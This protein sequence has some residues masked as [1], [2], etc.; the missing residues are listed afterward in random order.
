MNRKKQLFAAFVL[1][2]SQVLILF[3]VITWTQNQFNINTPFI[4][5]LS[6][7][8]IVLVSVLLI[9]TILTWVVPKFLREKL[10]SLMVLLTLFVFIQQNILV[11]DYG[12][13]DGKEIHFSEAGWISWVEF[14]MW[15]FGLF[16]LIFLNKKVLKHASLILTFSGLASVAVTFS[17][18]FSYDFA[19]N[20][21]SFAISE[22]QKFDY[23]KNKN[24]LVFLLDGFQSDLFTQIIEDEPEIK[25][26]F[27]GFDYYPNTTAVFSKTY[28]TIPLL[29]TGKTYQKK[30]GIH[31]F[32]VSAYQESLLTD[33][34]DAGWHVGLFPHIKKLLP[35]KNNIMS[36]AIDE[37]GWPEII[38]NY[39]QTLDLSL[40][41][42]VPHLI[43][44]S[45]YNQ[46]KMLLQKPAAQFIEQQKWF[47]DPLTTLHKMP[48]VNNHQGLNFLA[49]L[50]QHGST[51]Q[52]RPTFMFYHLMMP[53]SPFL[54][55]RN[56]SPVE[57]L[58]NFNAY[59]D[60]AYASLRLMI[61]YLKEL[62]ALGIYDQS[63]IMIMADHGGGEYTNLKFDS[64]INSFIPVNNH[65]YEKASAK[66][67][68]L[69]KDFQANGTFSV[70]QKP[71]SLLDV[72]PTL[73]DFSGLPF[74]ADGLP[75]KLIKENQARERFFYYY[76]FTG[77]DSKYLQD[78]NIFQI[79]GHVNDEAS[80]RHKGIL[81]V[82]DVA[83][84]KNNEAYHLNQIIRF[85]TDIKQD[86][87]HS[88]RF[89]TS[90]NPLYNNSSL[91]LNQTKTK[92]TIPMASPLIQGDTYQLILNMSSKEQT[93]S[94]RVKFNDDWSNP[95]SVEGESMDYHIPFIFRG[96]DL[97]KL[98]ITIDQMK[99]KVDAS[100]R[101]SKLLLKKINVVGLNSDGTDLFFD[102]SEDIS[103]IHPEGF[104]S[105]EKWGRWTAKEE[106]SVLFLGTKDFCHNKTVQL[107]VLKFQVGVI[108]DQFK[109]FLNDQK[110]TLLNK[111]T[112]N[113][114]IQL[115]YDCPIT[116]NHTS[117]LIKLTFE[118][119][120]TLAP[121]EISNSKDVRKL[122]M[123]IRNFA[124]KNNQ[125]N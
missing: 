118:T 110:L 116:F 80:W 2:L 25:S 111:K 100:I 69:V 23:S 89:I 24:I 117:N 37:N 32:L 28:P 73:A 36:N 40:L 88:N 85:G 38:K 106:S 31:E 20:S 22:K 96:S 14:A 56:L 10:L 15:G 35:V 75:I 119:N 109:V 115:T 84:V 125:L 63:A 102:F 59:H 72:M 103:A 12:V 107:N 95:V 97:K 120:T 29:L 49:N 122:G 64:D 55:D 67:L 66:P 91:T 48:K 79:K 16:V 123:G 101:V 5:G 71:V 77:F 83:K 52:D 44:P 17:S 19:G 74:E 87:D 65:G 41:R 13:L 104:W 121:S 51:S 46:G 86:A 81:T 113:Q 50:K 60:Y 34:I 18:L 94:L 99:D 42:T 33:L 39:S 98:D 54:L 76:N 124:I 62:K 26:E 61:A 27:S 7:L 21:R 45:V 8:F 58:H 108:I 92:L 3:P 82:S 68:M 47:D 93:Q 30:Q 11:S 70:S 112:S 114:G 4:E 57:N 43:K 53:H 6:L 105:A 78:F 90:K 1:V 9:S